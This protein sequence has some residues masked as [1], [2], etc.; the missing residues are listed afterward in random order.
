MIQTKER[1]QGVTARWCFIAGERGGVG[2]YEVELTWSWM[3]GLFHGSHDATAKDPRPPTVVPQPH[4]YM[5]PDKIRLLAK[6]R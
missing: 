3:K 5:K 1:G 6:T 4:I 2:F